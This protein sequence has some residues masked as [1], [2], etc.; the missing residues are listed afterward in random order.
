[1]WRFLPFGHW[2]WDFVHRLSG[3]WKITL[4]YMD[5]QY[6]LLIEYLVVHKQRDGFWAIPLLHVVLSTVEIW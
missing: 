5:S 1:M 4:H 3:A 6:L 2:A